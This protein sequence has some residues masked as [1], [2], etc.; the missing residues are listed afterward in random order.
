MTYLGAAPHVA[1]ADYYVRVP[2]I[3]KTRSARGRESHLNFPTPRRATIFCT[4]E[5]FSFLF[6]IS[7]GALARH[8]RG[9]AR[10]ESWVRNGG[11]RLGG[12]GDIRPQERTEVTQG[13]SHLLVASR[14][15][16]FLSNIGVLEL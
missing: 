3:E 14:S 15:A 6:D 10:V 1:A 4:C 2:R 12:L 8:R 16:F 9:C 5:M 11:R 7:C 13:S